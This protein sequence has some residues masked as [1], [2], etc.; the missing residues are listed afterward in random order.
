MPCV[1]CNCRFFMHY[2]VSERESERFPGD[3]SRVTSDESML[4]FLPVCEF[5]HR[6]FRA[7]V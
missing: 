1:P 3:I 6:I 4:L 5:V 7:N 2:L